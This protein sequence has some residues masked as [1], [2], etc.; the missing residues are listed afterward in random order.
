MQPPRY[1]GASNIEH[2]NPVSMKTRVRTP[3]TKEEARRVWI[4]AFWA[5]W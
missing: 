3:E 4:V 1:S 5:D 2:L